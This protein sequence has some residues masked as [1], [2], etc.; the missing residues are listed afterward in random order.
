VA[1]DIWI[2]S[3]GF[4]W[5]N[6]VVYV[7]WEP[8]CFSFAGGE[9]VIAGGTDLP[10]DDFSNPA[11]IGFAGYGY[12]NEQGVDLLARLRL[13]VEA[14]VTCCASPIIDPNNPYYTLSQLGR[15]SLYVLFAF[16]DVTCW[17]S[18]APPEACCFANGSCSDLTPSECAAAGGTSRGSGT[19]CATVEC[20]SADGACLHALGVRDARRRLPG[21]RDHVR[22]GHLPAGDRR[23]L[24]LRR[25]VHLLP[26]A[27][28]VRS[29]AGRLPGRRNGVFHGELPCRDRRLL[30][31]R[32]GLREPVASG[33][34]AD[35]RRLHRGW[36]ELRDDRLPR[37]ARGLLP[38]GRGVRH[39]KP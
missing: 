13:R 28:G 31:P 1:V 30:L 34:R 36:H 27:R 8:G 20:P 17:A 10:I 23:V 11:A 22:Y 39:G 6:F 33:L 12:A 32:R 19:T 21:G 16:A 7:E 37:S 2:D 14:P 38:T 25:R 3:S 29:G 24:L 18:D 5:T 9:Y 15:G 35:G 4:L 26:N